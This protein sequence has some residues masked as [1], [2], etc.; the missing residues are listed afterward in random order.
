MLL[1]EADELTHRVGKQAAM[2]IC[3]AR[4]ATLKAYSPSG[5]GKKFEKSILSLFGGSIVDTSSTVWCYED[6]GGCICLGS[7]YRCCACDR[8]GNFRQWLIQAPLRFLIGQPGETL[9][10]LAIVPYSA[11]EFV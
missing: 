3:D 11:K 5:K 8:S 10:Q 9:P 2:L 6:S 1:M 7:G 4:P